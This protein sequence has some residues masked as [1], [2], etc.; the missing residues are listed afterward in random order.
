MSAS[1][2]PSAFNAAKRAF[3]FA[4]FWSS[5]LLCAVAWVCT[6]SETTAS[7]GL[8][9]IVAVPFTVTV[10]PAGVSADASCARRGAGGHDRPEHDAGEHVAETL[11]MKASSGWGTIV[12][13]RGEAMR[14]PTIPR[15]ACSSAWLEQGAFNPRVA[16]SNP[17]R[18]TLRVGGAAYGRAMRTERIGSLVV[19]VPQNKRERRRG[20]LGRAS[21]SRS[22]GILL[23][24]C[25]S[26]HTFGMRFTIDA[27][28]LDGSFRVLQVVRMPPGRLLLP[29]RGVRHILEVSAGRAPRRGERLR[30]P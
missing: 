24:R 5:A 9:L 23:E 19:E 13:R 27:V 2:R 25:R 17:A 11:H 21:L 14:F 22:G 29:R 3:I 30:G 18:P 4:A 12:G 15:G 28:L 6:P 8:A 1:V 10:R 7:S 20:L 26:V 16:G